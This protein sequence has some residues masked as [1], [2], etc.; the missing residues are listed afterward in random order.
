MFVY[1]DVWSEYSG[2][3]VGFLDIGY[4]T[5]NEPRLL[6]YEFIGSGTADSGTWEWVRGANG[7]EA[8][9]TS[10]IRKVKV[11]ILRSTN[12][13]EKNPPS[14]PWFADSKRTDGNTLAY[15]DMNG[16]TRSCI[17]SLKK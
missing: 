7:A 17:W 10:S 4:H 9:L 11:A 13:G 3:N 15:F 1:L 8:H 14:E 2:K 16:Q 12:W 6:V 5:M